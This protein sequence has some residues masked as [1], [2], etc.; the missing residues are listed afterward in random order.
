MAV[1]CQQ[2]QIFALF[3]NKPSTEGTELGW[4][5]VD[6]HEAEDMTNDSLYLS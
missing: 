5:H 6:H 4:A 1:G 2:I 3:A